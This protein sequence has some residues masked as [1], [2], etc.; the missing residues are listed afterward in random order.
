MRRLKPCD[1]VNQR[2]SVIAMTLIETSR[3]PFFF[4]SGEKQIIGIDREKRAL[5]HR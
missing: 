1:L 3:V 5:K 2:Q 4:Y